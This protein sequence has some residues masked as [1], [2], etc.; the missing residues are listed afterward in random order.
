MYVGQVELMARDKH[1]RLWFSDSSAQARRD[2]YPMDKLH[3]R[4]DGLPGQELAS[5]HAEIDAQINAEGNRRH[6]NE[7]TLNRLKKEKLRIK[8]E[9]VVAPLH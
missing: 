9:L 3:S 8:D 2:T 5:K 4:D 1:P 6:P 7:T